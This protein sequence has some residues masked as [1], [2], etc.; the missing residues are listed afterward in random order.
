MSRLGAWAGA[1]PARADTP[2]EYAEKLSNV[3]PGQEP[4]LRRLSD[5][6]ARERWGGGLRGESAEELPRVYE[7]V[8]RSITPV[9]IQ[10]ARHLPLAVLRFGRHALRRSRARRRGR[11]QP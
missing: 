5:L 3:I 9:I 10:R 2:D 6:Y 8:R 11:R 1:P 7:Q 4:S